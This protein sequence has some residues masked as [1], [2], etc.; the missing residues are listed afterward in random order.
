ME[1][2]ASVL[3][4][5]APIIE[6]LGLATVIAAFSSFATYKLVIM[7]I[8][9]S[10]KREQIFDSMVEQF[11]DVTVD[12]AKALQAH[13]DSCRECYRSMDQSIVEARNE[14][15]EILSFVRRRAGN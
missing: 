10:W 14:H 6:R 12:V 5:F 4:S 7:V 3:T 2:F 15:S 11:K 8:Q 9:H 13:T 1:H